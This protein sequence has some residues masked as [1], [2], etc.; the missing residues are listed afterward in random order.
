MLNK[1][2]ARNKKEV[3]VLIVG[4][5]GYGFYYVK[6]LLEDF[7]RGKIRISGVVD[8]LAK[9]SRY[10]LELKSRKAPFF[11]T[12]EDFFDDG[13]SAELAIISSPIHHHVQQTITALKYG[14]NVLME[15]PAGATVQDVD[16]LISI[17]KES[18][19]WVM[20]GYQW[21]Y[22]DSI[23]ALIRDIRKGIFGKPVRFKT[24]CFWPRTNEYYTRNN[25][26]GKQA[27]ADG[28]WILDSPA[29]NAMA[30][31][32]HNLLFV[33]GSYESPNLPA[34][35]EAELYRANTI[36]NY[37]TAACRIG[38]QS[39]AELLFYG[40][41][42]TATGKGPM[43]N[44]EF[45]NATVSYG[46]SSDEIVAID[47]NGIRRSYGSPDREHQFKKLFEAVEAAGR[48][49]DINPAKDNPMEI[50][51]RT[52]NPIN[53]VCGLKQSRPQ[54]LCMNG[55][56]ESMRN[57]RDFPVDM[58]RFDESDKRYYVNNLDIELYD[59]YQQNK[60]PNEAG[61]GWAEK[62][63]VVKLENY[64]FFPGKQ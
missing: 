52:V 8:P 27:A 2:T 5:G 10:Y 4:I 32:L 60:L 22:S 28:S 61:L 11:N 43:F 20:V 6:S 29:N 62:G 39:G 21:S 38:L 34:I 35:V 64:T 36:E 47:S 40:T 1:T 33:S 13:N 45:E 16:R 53:I 12:I 23:R 48:T 37:D 56:Q 17:E 44:L 58:I 54:T 57:I 25:W 50:N 42:A 51:S 59:C 7:Q 26:A 24:L 9:Q 15:K 63:K 30:H 49:A 31:F 14:C 3:T 55:I 41:H 19:K 18:G 46:E